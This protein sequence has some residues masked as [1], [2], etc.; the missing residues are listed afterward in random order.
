MRWGLIAFLKMG[1]R[2]RVREARPFKVRPAENGPTISEPASD[3]QGST[4]P[5]SSGSK[6]KRLDKKVEK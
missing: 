1:F 4:P 5:P 2:E 6:T 3:C